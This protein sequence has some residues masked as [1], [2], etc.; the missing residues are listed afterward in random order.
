MSLEER[1][2]AAAKNVEGKVQEAVGNIT[3]DPADKMEG[4]AKQAEAGARNA[5]EDVKD[6]AKDVVD[7]A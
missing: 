5:K 7:R 3:N 4:K 2:K 6:A 1:A